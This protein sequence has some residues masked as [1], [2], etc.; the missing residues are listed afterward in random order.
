[1]FSLVT[2]K[3]DWYLVPIYPALSII[4]GWHIARWDDDRRASG[5][6]IPHLWTIGTAAYLALFV[7]VS[8]IVVYSQEKETDQ[9]LWMQ[10][11]PQP[12]AVIFLKEER[13]QADLY[14]ANAVKGFPVREALSLDDA[15]SNIRP[16]EVLFTRNSSNTNI[17]GLEL[18]TNSPWGW[19]F[20]K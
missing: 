16:G 13:N 15:L 6:K 3:V 8:A 20:R 14:I 12:S 4:V 18:Q 9:K 11:K 1:M 2:T 7:V 10:L 5:K 17:P 19:W